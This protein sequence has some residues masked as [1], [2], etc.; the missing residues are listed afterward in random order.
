MPNLS[1]RQSLR[2]PPEAITRLKT[3]SRLSG[4]FSDRQTPHDTRRLSSVR[5]G[6]AFYHR[7][8]AS[9]GHMVSLHARTGEE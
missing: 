5:F 7:V 8:E 2:V 4:T 3:R 9:H 6:H 1:G